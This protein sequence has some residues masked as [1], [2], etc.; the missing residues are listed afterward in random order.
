MFG[1]LGRVWNV[2]EW[3]FGASLWVIVVGLVALPVLLVP[4]VAS[5]DPPGAGEAPRSVAAFRTSPLLP[6][7]AGAA[8]MT[9]WTTSDFNGWPDIFPLLPFAAVGFAG[10]VH[11]VVRR[12]RPPVGDA[13]AGAIVACLIVLAV[14]MA[15]GTRSNAIDEQRAAVHELLDQLPR[16]ATILSIN[17]PQ[18][19]VLSGRT[20]PSRHQT[21]LRGLH[22][23]IEDTYPGGLDAFGA[24]VA[25]EKP[26]VI[27]LERPRPPEWLE[28]ALDRD[29]RFVG[30]APGWAWYVRYPEA[31]DVSL[32]AV[33]S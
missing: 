6:I 22:D 32:T 4:S 26:T 13:L 7:V 21:F 1:H 27:A 25:S 3:G 8:V 19:L 20:N 24:W 30:M 10:L 16:D 29:Y 28:T 33:D 5:P 14:N 15:V 2:L 9:V 18:A 11:A 31:N 23:Y 17:S 12:L